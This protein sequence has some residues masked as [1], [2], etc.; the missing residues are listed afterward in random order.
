MAKIPM[1]P[2][3]LPTEYTVLNDTLTYRA[4]V[5][6]LK[7]SDKTDRNGNYF[8]I[9]KYEIMEPLEFKGKHITDHYIGLPGVLDPSMGAI[10]RQRALESAVKLGRL[11]KSAGFKTD[12][13][14][15]DTD[16][17]L[18]TTIEFDIKNEDYN[19]R[20]SSKINNYLS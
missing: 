2:S 9:G 15:F 11:I 19:G 4:V 18:G 3:D 12:A 10:E 13:T 17:L 14:E 6:E 7:L 5:K 1:N 20:T 8:L 16:E